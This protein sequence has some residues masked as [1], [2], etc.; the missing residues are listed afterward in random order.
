MR[1]G[2][3]SLVGMVLLLASYFAVVNYFKKIREEKMEWHI[4]VP[5]TKNKILYLVMGVVA[6]TGLILAFQI[7]YEHSTILHQVKL[8]T[9]VSVIM[10]ISAVD[11]K[12]KKIPNE[13]LIIGFVARIGIAIMEVIFYKKEAFALLKDGI[14][15]AIIIAL[16]FFIIL[17]IARNSIGMGDVKLF[18]L[19]ATYQG[20]WGVINSIFF[21]F[22]VS[23]L[24][25][26]GL[27]LTRK[28]GRKDAIPFGPS[29]FIGTVIAIAISGI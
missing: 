11:Y 21:S 12:T 1:V 24:L 22:V 6:L 10:A 8:L 2:I 25:S 9:L 19:M 18:I 29:I 16:I 27:L 5:K 17:L 15:A 3:E 14:V 23:F 13:F 4:I 20:L 26:I 28:K 7:Y